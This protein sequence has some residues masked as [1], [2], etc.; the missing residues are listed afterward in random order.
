MASCG[1]PSKAPAGF[2]YAAQVVAELVKTHS[3]AR[4]LIRGA[5]GYQR[6]D[7]TPEIWAKVVDEI[8]KHLNLQSSNR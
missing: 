7:H 2:N 5:S 3:Q 6:L 1:S 4:V 8:D